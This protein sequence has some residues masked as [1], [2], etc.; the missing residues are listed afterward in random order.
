MTSTP[1]GSKLTC[2]FGSVHKGILVRA[3]KLRISYPN[4]NIV[5]AN[6]VK[7]CFHQIKNHPNVAGAFSYIL[8]NYLFLQI[9]LAF[10]ADFSTAN[11]EAVR[12]TQSTLAERSFSTHPWS[13][14]TGTF[15]IR[16][17]GVTSCTEKSAHI[18][19]K[20]STMH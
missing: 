10:G 13:K 4:T 17:C 3:Y 14:N 11:C 9:G 2:L 15:S 8:A 18:S 6:D 16:L 19:P 20:P 12:R 7:S 5:V 1:H